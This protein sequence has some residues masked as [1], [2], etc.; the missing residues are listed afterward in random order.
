MA[1][2]YIPPL[3][4]LK[5]VEIAPISRIP[6][7][8]YNWEDWDLSGVIPAGAKYVDVIIRQTITV[9]T[10]RY[11][12]ARKK[13]SDVDRRITLLGT[14]G[15]QLAIHFTVELPPSRIIQT[16][17]SWGSGAGEDIRQYVTG[18]WI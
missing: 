8:Y 2:K 3:F 15:V 10:A 14:D 11:V 1:A 5:F 7:V 17:Q 12:G 13:G 18:Y 6:Q 9:G 16:Y 4:E